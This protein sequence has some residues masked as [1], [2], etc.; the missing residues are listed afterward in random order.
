MWWRGWF[1][2][3]KGDVIRE[4]CEHDKGSE[5]SENSIS[6]KEIDCTAVLVL[7]GSRLSSSWLTSFCLQYVCICSAM[8]KIVALLQLLNQS[9]I[10][11]KSNS[12]CSTISNP[13]NPTVLTFQHT[14]WVADKR[15]QITVFNLTLCWLFFRNFFKT[16]NHHYCFRLGKGGTMNRRLLEW[17]IERKS[18]R[19]QWNLRL[20]IQ[21]QFIEVFTQRRAIAFSIQWMLHLERNLITRVLVECTKM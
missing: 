12:I 2:D 6:L 11:A 4:T 7:K 19:V 5:E 3:G 18:S 20:D 8:L 21:I 10:H 1:L 13:S 15:E 14:N 16:F 17:K 9:K